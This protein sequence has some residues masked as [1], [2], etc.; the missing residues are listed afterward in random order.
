MAAGRALLWLPTV[1][2]SD[3]RPDGLEG[4]FATDHVVEID[5][6]VTDTIARLRIVSLALGGRRL[7]R[8]PDSIDIRALAAPIRRCPRAW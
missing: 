8:G 1:V 3:E 2:E 6:A 7:N 5:S 4:D